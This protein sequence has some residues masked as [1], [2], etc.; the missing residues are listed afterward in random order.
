MEKENP[1]ALKEIKKERIK[2]SKKI[3]EDILRESTYNIDEYR[4]NK[5][6]INKKYDKLIRKLK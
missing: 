4:E 3:I 5:E 1:E 6:I 2:N